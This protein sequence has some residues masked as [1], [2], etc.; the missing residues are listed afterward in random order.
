MKRRSINDIITGEIAHLSVCYHSVYH[1]LLY[2]KIWHFIFS[3][4]SRHLE[5]V[6]ARKNG[7]ERETHFS[8]RVSPSRAPVLFCAHYFQAPAT[9]A[10]FYLKSVVCRL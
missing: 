5:V 3:L 10:I 7:R 9:Q 1:E 4:L 6:G 2:N 8:P